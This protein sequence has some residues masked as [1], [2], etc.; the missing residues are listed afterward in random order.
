[1]TT[2]HI[3]SLADNR[4]DVNHVVR[5]IESVEASHQTLTG[6]VNSL[7]QSQTLF[8]YKHE[9]ANRVSQK[10][11]TLVEKINE[12]GDN[13][14]QRVEDMLDDR[15]KRLNDNM[16][17][18]KQILMLELANKTAPIVDLAVRVKKTE[19]DVNTLNKIIWI[20]MGGAAVISFL[21]EKLFSVIT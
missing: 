16:T 20:A 12:R 7:A 1:M 6:L 19:D 14:L 10:L 13:Q 2:T 17:Q 18:L 5:R 15:E 21:I 4:R 11:E 3:D 9:Q 8:E